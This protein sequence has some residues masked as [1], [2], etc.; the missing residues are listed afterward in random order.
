[1]E[2]LGYGYKN[3]HLS[4]EDITEFVRVIWSRWQVAIF[5]IYVPALYGLYVEDNLI[6]FDKGNL[7]EYL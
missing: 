2:F 3:I 7:K 6:F 5:V 4:V 1:M